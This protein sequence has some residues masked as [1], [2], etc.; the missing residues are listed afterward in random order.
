M[1]IFITG[2]TS[3]IG[4]G[5]AKEYL[6]Q[7]YEVAVCGRN[8]KKIS[9]LKEKYPKLK[10]YK[11]DVKD[12][13]ELK[14]AVENFSQ[15]HLDI[16]IANA[17]TYSSNRAKKLNQDELINSLDVNLTGALHALEIGRD[18]MLKQNEGQLVV[19]SSVAGLLEYPDASVYSKSKRALNYVCEA[20][21]EALKGSNI[22]ITNI[23]P[24]YVETERLRDLNA[25]DTDKK[26]F[27]ISENEAVRIII[28]AIKKKKEKEIFPKKM[29]IAISIIS[30]LPKS[31]INFLFH[32]YEKENGE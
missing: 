26:A 5:L 7:G 6:L 18:I 32:F 15:D 29:K 19:I 2:G 1:K 31:L 12:K 9:D 14:K 23:L 30:K 28:E 20:Y 13:F 10:I 16:M 4:L 17:G 21:R 11:V 27:I 25:E 22:K 3:G 8:E 24:G